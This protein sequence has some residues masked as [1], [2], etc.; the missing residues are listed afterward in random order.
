MKHCLPRIDAREQSAKKA[1]NHVE[2]MITPYSVTGKPQDGSAREGEGADT[3]SQAL[4]SATTIR[5]PQEP[6][7]F[8]IRVESSAKFNLQASLEDIQK[9]THD[10]LLQTNEVSPMTRKDSLNSTFSHRD[11]IQRLSHQLENEKGTISQVLDSYRQGWHQVMDQLF[12]AH[13][14]RIELY[15]QQMQAV[16]KQHSDLCQDLIRRL[17]ENDKRIQERLRGSV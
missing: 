13:E 7:Q 3:A 12:K 14:E 11:S 8:G 1:D 10:F 15:R 16:R 9:T 2:S 6:M 5:L 17:E 4:S